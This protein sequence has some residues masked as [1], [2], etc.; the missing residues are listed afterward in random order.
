MPN[1]TENIS[2]ARLAFEQ[3]GRRVIEGRFDS[4]HM[5]SD[6]GVMLLATLDQHLRLTNAAARSIADPR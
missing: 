4:R 6:G 3:L 5:T 1:C 2:S